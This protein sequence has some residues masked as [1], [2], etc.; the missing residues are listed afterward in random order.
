MECSHELTVKWLTLVYF[1]N[2]R[3]GSKES[4]NLQN[5][6]DQPQSYGNTEGFDHPEVGADSSTVPSIIEYERPE[7]STQYGKA[8]VHTVSYNKNVLS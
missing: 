1:Y 8:S 5:S 3:L 2:Y 7:K 6:R 4:H